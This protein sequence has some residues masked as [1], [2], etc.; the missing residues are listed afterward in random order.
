MNIFVV[1]ITFILILLFSTNMA[2]TFL[3][4]NIAGILFS[5]VNNKKIYL[6]II[7]CITFFLLQTFFFLFF[8]DAA[9][10]PA[11]YILKSDYSLSLRMRTILSILLFPNILSFLVAIIINSIYNRRNEETPQ[12]D[13]VE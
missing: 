1:A 4:Y 10:L 6:T 5:I 13:G 2:I 3:L 8:G 12:D 11:Y 7:S 9:T